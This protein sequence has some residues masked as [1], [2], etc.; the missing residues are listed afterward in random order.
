MRRA[1]L[2]LA[3]VLSPA[4]VAQSGRIASDFEIQQMKE[5]AATARDF[6]DMLLAH[7]NLGDLRVDRNESVL[8]QAE[9]TQALKIAQDERAA[10]RKKG[11]EN[12][13]ANATIYAGLAEAKLGHERQAFEL[14]EEA[15]RYEPD[16]SKIWNVYSSAMHSLKLPRKA[17]SAS[18]N[19][20]A[21]AN[22][23][24]DLAIYQF[25]LALALLDSDEIAEGTKILE[26]VVA[27]LKSKTFEAV[28]KSA[29]R[30]E[31]FEIYATVRGD[32]AAYISLV[33]HV[34]LQLAIV[35]ESQG[36]LDQARKVYEDVLKARTD[37]ATALSALARLGK[38]NEAFADAFDANPFSIEL[39][40]DYRRVLH[41]S[42]PRTEGTSTG[43]KMRRAL[44]QMSRREYRAAR[45]TLDA[46][47]EQFPTNDV[48][49]Y[50]EA[51]N[52]IGLGDLESARRRS[53]QLPE[54]A[55]E[56]G[57]AMQGP[58]VDPASFLVDLGATLNMLTRNALT[59]EQR[60]TMDH[61]TLTST[62]RF[63][64]AQ[65][66]AEGQTI[67]E[68]GKIENVPFRFAQPT[69]FKGTFSAAAPLRLTYRILGA[70]ELNGVSALLV[71]PMKVEAR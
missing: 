11:D 59:P 44:E 17:A 50:L 62:V 26:T 64:A 13:Y 3:L 30:K 19:A 34:Q 38:S 14:V 21:L 27:S 10:A 5:L 48:V 53:I 49:Q 66:A 56:V 58:A 69:A 28:R 29:A 9:Y 45:E 32:E 39:I 36:K 57:Q 6:N 2:V 61:S 65:S 54:L 46:L 18:R 52:D 42:G 31:A 1:A 33:N 40:R 15:I 20:V 70:T 43:A 12:R 22:N 67:L 47:R 24:T 4:V 23:P 16:E 68:S 63:D 55:A 41:S 35:Y 60:V 51:L 25:G 71:E 37:D 7:L 8:A